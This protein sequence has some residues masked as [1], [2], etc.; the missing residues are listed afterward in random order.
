MWTSLPYNNDIVLYLSI[1]EHGLPLA[2]YAIDRTFNVFNDHQ[3]TSFSS[4][5]LQGSHLD[6]MGNHDVV[7]VSS[8]SLVQ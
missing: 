8:E 1:L 2:T 3:Y 6:Q 4:V 7:P 5:K